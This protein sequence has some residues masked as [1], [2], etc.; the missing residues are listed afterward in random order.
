[1]N[2]PKF[3]IG[4]F[5]W[6]ASVVV[7]YYFGTTINTTRVAEAEPVEQLELT[8]KP[9]GAAT[10]SG[11]AQGDRA[12]SAGEL[13]AISQDDL[14]EALRQ[15]SDLDEAGK[16]ELLAEAFALPETDYRRSRM[17]RDLLGE[18]AKTA[19][20]DALAMA[21]TVGSLRDAQRARENVLEV[22]AGNDPAAAL[23]WAETAL[24]DEP[25]RSRTSQMLA[26]FRGYAEN[27]PQAAFSSA[28]TMQTDTIAQKRIQTYALQE[29]I[30][31][32]ISNGGLLEAKQ[33][34]ELMEDGSNKTSL[35]SELVDRWAS[36]DPEGAAEYVQSLGDKAS[37]AVKSRLLG[38]WAEK[39]PAAAAAWLNAQDVDERTLRNAST[40]IIREWTRYDMAA[41]AEWLN[42]QPASDALDRAVMSYTY[43]AAQEDPASAMTWAQSIG[44]NWMRTRMMRHVAGNWKNDNPEAFQEFIEN[45]DMNDDEKK[46]LEAAEASTGGGRYW[47]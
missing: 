30:A 35:M 20:L 4:L 7:A 44:N 5:V 14:P 11:A 8:K 42:A 21:D 17:L 40:A 16:R 31:E 2:I 47:R 34:V 13:L 29:I 1:M 46:S 45:A 9:T 18:L 25:L 24:A 26:I 41:S 33:Q 19:P 3:L 28:L 27:N 6:L 38:E 39:D 43:R 12:L 22:W 10:T 36:Y 15:A 32:Q 23:A 37:S